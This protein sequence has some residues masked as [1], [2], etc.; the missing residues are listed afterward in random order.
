MSITSALES[1]LGINTDKKSAEKY[2]YGV[3]DR[4][5]AN[6]LVTLNDWLLDQTP[7]K[8]KEK[9]LL[10]YSLQM[11]VN[12]GVEFTRSVEI[13]GDRARNPRLKR[14]LNTIS[15][16]MR[17]RGLSFSQALAKY[18]KV[19]KNATIK[20]IYSGEVTGKIEETLESISEQIQKNLELESQIKSAMMYPATVLGAIALAV[21]A[22]MVLVVPQF[23]TLFGQFGSELPGST[24]FLIG[25]SDFFANFWWGVLVLLVLAVLGFKNWKDTEKGQIAFSTFLFRVPAIKTI[26]K[27]IQTV[28]ISSN[29]GTLL[30]S[31]VSIDRALQILSEVVDNALV[32]QKLKDI[33]ARV[34]RGERLSAALWEHQPQLDPV[35]AEITDIGEKTG[36]LPTVLIK[37]AQQYQREVDSQLKNLTQIIEPVIIVI[38]AGAVIFMAMA[39]LSP[40]FQLQSLFSTV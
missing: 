6:F 9:G 5:S 2:I 8:T 26:V 38:V 3:T 1:A 30:A 20:M 23:M 34:M 33:Q 15:H 11:L 4:R 32:S 27:N 36:A 31:G 28:K 22:V 10:F 18:P 7:V 40:I 29:L 25:A 39:I 16:D 17:V 21:G 12:S 14:I 35:L 24:K 37:T 19:F 13:L